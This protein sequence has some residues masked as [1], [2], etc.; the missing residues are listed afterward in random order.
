MRT[1]ALSL[2]TLAAMA[3]VCGPAAGQTVRGVVTDATTGE[4]LA[5]AW[6][7]A[8]DSREQRVDATLTRGDG[9][10]QVHAAGA[11]T[12]SA[13]FLGFAERRIDLTG[14]EPGDTLSIDVGLTSRPLTLEGIEVVG[15]ERCGGERFRAADAARVWEEATNALEVADWTV[16]E[17]LF[18]Y[19]VERYS[20]RLDDDAFRVVSEERRERPGWGLRPFRS[21]D[22]SE[23]AE[24]GYVRTVDGQTVYYAPD[25]DVLLSDA[26]LRTH[27]FSVVVGSGEHAGQVGLA[28]RPTADRSVPEIMGEFWLDARTSRLTSMEF[29]YVGLERDID[30]SLLGGKVSFEPVEDGPII[31][32][33]WWIRTPV[34]GLQ[35][36][37]GSARTREVVVGI[38]E[39]G[40]SVLQLGRM[41]DVAAV[42]RPGSSIEGRVVEEMTDRPLEGATVRLAGTPYVAR[43]GADGS[44]VIRGARAGNYGVSVHHPKLDRLGQDTVRTVV[45]LT[46]PTPDPLHIVVPGVESVMSRRCARLTGEEPDPRWGILRGT[47]ID[48]GTGVPLPDVTVRASWLD[49]ARIDET[50]FDGRR[51]WTEVSTDG[52][53]RFLI[54]GVPVPH[55]VSL[56]AT[57][58][59]VEGEAAVDL[60]PGAVVDTTLALPL[61]GAMVV[62]GTVRDGETMSPVA[63]AEVTIGDAT[64]LSDGRGSFLLPSL[65]AGL[66]EVRVQHMAYGERIDSVLVSGA[67][68]V[69]ME[70]TLMPEAFELKGLTVEVESERAARYRRYRARGTRVDVMEREAIEKASLGASSV[71]DVLVSPELPFL[72]AYE[73]SFPIQEG[74]N[75][76]VRRGICVELSRQRGGGC[77]MPE[78]YLNGAPLHQPEFALLDL[79]PASIQRIEVVPPLEAGAVLGTQGGDGAIYI[80]LQGAGPG[81]R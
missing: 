20:R 51:P 9:F 6:L 57:T 30:T 25:M 63:G 18:R 16:N 59:G 45:S 50:G 60:R 10:F 74:D 75:R 52:E 11:T 70:I 17:G 62:M 23:L 29:R 78:V 12:L 32:D 67:S 8:L 66:H 2:A 80:Y 14:A 36:I 33:E 61:G 72:R 48:G 19:Q 77:R 27:C 56:T 5:G 13:S 76:F 3:C 44:F 46:G 1:T 42:D 49:V 40:G 38:D 69:S 39:S 41:G 26:F 79:D 22:A 55:H 37:A 15:E 71:A 64:V 81:E 43:T 68:A 35:P 21:P 73:V 34:V 53:G 7:Q 24:H 47:V 65:T 31:V 54:C 28:F 4:P 58:L